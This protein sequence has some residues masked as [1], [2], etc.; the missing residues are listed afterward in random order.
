MNDKM[1][2]QVKCLDGHIIRTNIRAKLCRDGTVDLKNRASIDVAKSNK[3][4][5]SIDV[6]EDGKTLD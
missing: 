2:L 6:N 1:F 4:D 3:T 5:L